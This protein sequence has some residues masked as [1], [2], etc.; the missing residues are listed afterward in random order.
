MDEVGQLLMLQ[1]GV[2]SRRQLL[3]QGVT[4]GAIERHL[5]RRELVRF[6]PGVFLEHGGEPTW[7]QRAWAMVLN[8]APAAL[9]GM[10]ALRAVAGPGWRQHCDE[11]PIHVAVD[12]SR[13]VR[14]V[15]GSRVD[16]MT[17]L[18]ENVLW[19]ASPPRVRPEVA[20]I[21]V[22]AAA[23]GEL[24]RISVLADLCQSRRTTTDRLLAALD[25][26]PRV[27]GRNWLRSVLIDVRD[28]TCS[29][30]EHGYLTRVERP[31]GLPIGT[32]QEGSST[33]QGHV[34]RDVV[35]RAYGRIVELDGRLFHDTAGQRDAD[36]DRD[37]DAAV[38]GQAT[39]R[40][41]WGQVFDRPCRTTGR[42][43]V[44]LQRGGWEGSPISCGPG[45][46]I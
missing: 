1:S 31:H 21:V 41:G 10:S 38:A 15:A 4:A 43:A 3:A 8:Y 7:I 12:V 19:N 13:T 29:V 2:I 22:A 42:L 17:A 32:R 30:L 14:R 34:L 16:R 27:R 24:R 18:E 11:G 40:L 23:E 45:C 28:G 6:L 44:L 35:Y 46:A 37:L 36:L 9:T 39:V 33:T 25:S 5:R 20:G 26:R